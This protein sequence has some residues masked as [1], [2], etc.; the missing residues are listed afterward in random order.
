MGQ[1]LRAVTRARFDAK[2]PPQI[3]MAS[4]NHIGARRKM[5]RSYCRR[6]E[7]RNQCFARGICFSPTMMRRGASHWSTPFCQ[8]AKGEFP[9]L[10]GRFTRTPLFRRQVLRHS[11][12]STPLSPAQ[13]G[14]KYNDVLY[15]SMRSSCARICAAITLLGSV[16]TVSISR[17]NHSALTNTFATAATASD[18]SLP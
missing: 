16:R 11:P 7:L 17:F 9:F 8:Q 1:K 3:V 13:V 5:M 14:D 2:P 15:S 10:F 12:C 18:R 4:I 6:C